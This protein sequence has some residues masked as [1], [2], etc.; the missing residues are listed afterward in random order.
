M[1][2]FALTV[3]R[4]A[5]YVPTR[6]RDI[7]QAF[8]ELYPLSETDVL[9][10]IGSGDGKVCLTAAQRGARAVG[11]EINPL[12]VAV[13]WYRAR[14]QPLASFIWADFWRRDLPDDTSIVYTFGDSRDIDRMA[15]RVEQQAARLSRP[16]YFLSYAFELPG[17]ES[18]HKNSSFFL[19]RIEPT[20]HTD[21]PQV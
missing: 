6:R 17:L 18:L 14:H 19:Y 3:L 4:G 11:Y 7:E 8:D 2:I 15:R 21:K 16:L 9:V 20:L 1:A 5:P 10:D 13:S 12:L